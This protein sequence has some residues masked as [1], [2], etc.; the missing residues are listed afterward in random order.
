MKKSN[1]RKYFECQRFSFLHAISA[2]MKNSSHGSSNSPYRIHWHIIKYKG[3]AVMDKIL[4][5]NDW[6]IGSPWDAYLNSSEQSAPPLKFRT[7]ETMHARAS[8]RTRA[9]YTQI[10][11]LVIVISAPD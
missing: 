5:I 9:S 1:R 8:N 7:W 6:I 2:A 10:V 11:N 3:L 4:L